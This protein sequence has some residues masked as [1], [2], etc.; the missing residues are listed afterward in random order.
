MPYERILLPVAGVPDEGVV[1]NAL[2]LAGSPDASIHVLSV[3]D[4]R[5]FPDPASLYDA[6]TTDAATEELLAH[7]ER[8]GER[9]VRVVENELS[10]RQPGCDIVTHVGQGVPADVIHRYVE[11]NGIEAVV[12][13]THERTAPEER[14]LG[15][16]TERV[17]RA[18]TVPVL[19]I[20]PSV[21]GE[22]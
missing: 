19:V 7:Y 20:P 5:R 18:G 17:I 9:A 4:E 11:E 22:R 14:L 21:S 10:T 16:A 8:E 15:S 3:V 13:A 1:S 6:D 12:M 2:V